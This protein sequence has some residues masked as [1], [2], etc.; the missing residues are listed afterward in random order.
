MS[1]SLK[2][3]L[4]CKFYC[5]GS[6][7]QTERRQVFSINIDKPPKELSQTEKAAIFYNIEH[8]PGT[9]D[10]KIDWHYM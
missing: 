8:C 3:P 6:P 7:N 4:P 5:T 1:E 2:K 9:C 10:E